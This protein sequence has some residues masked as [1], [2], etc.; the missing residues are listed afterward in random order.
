VDVV[1]KLRDIYTPAQIRT[2]KQR[3]EEPRQRVNALKGKKGKKLQI[4]RIKA[5]K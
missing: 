5:T 3:L 1:F 2:I 4:K